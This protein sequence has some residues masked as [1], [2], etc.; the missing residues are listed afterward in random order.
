MKELVRNDASASFGQLHFQNMRFFFK[1]CTVRLERLESKPRAETKT[2]DENINTLNQ[3][4]EPNGQNVGSPA[5]R[6]RTRSSVLQTDNNGDG[7]I[8]PKKANTA[9]VPRPKPAFIDYKGKVEY[10]TEFHDIAFASDN[11]LWVCVWFSSLHTP[12]KPHVINVL[13]DLGAKTRI[14]WNDSDRIWHGM[15]VYIS[16]RARQNG[17]HT[18][19][20][21]HR[22][23]LCVACCQFKETA[24]RIGATVN[25]RQSLFARCKCQKVSLVD[26]ASFNFLHTQTQK[27]CVYFSRPPN[28]IFA[29]IV[30]NWNVIFRKSTDKRW[31]INA[32]I[33]VCIATMLWIPAA[34]G[35]W[36]DSFGTLYVSYL[37]G[38]RFLSTH[39]VT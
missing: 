33:W 18:V 25:A 36:N 29:A 17:R 13:Q 22:C 15:A 2:I 34:A 21:E 14:K 3:I 35:V 37:V 32:L 27:L 20:L 26:L 8:Q 5:K 23:V 38:F 1:E 6:Y 4:T 31:S 10:H 16:N 30:A 24:G 11:L 28:E 7:K 39:C 12:L 19:M 9:A